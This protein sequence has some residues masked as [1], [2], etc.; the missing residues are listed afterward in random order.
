MK[1]LRY[2]LLGEGIVEDEF[3]SVYLEKVAIEKG[4][5]L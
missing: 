1:V 3:L 5:R 4:I 2:A